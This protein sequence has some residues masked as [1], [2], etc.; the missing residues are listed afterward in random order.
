MGGGN[1]APG[2]QTTV[3]YHQPTQEIPPGYGPY[4]QPQQQFYPG[5]PVPQPYYHPQQQGGPYSQPPGF[6][7]QP[8]Y[9]PQ[10]GYPNQ[11]PPYK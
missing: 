6:P 8:G 2:G 4:A 1:R 7:Q 11:M 9:Y 10:G 5:Q 3:Y